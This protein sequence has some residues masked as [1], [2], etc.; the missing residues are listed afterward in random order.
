MQVI[1]NTMPPTLYVMIYPIVQ[2]LVLKGAAIETV[3][4]KVNATVVA[5][6]ANVAVSIKNVT[7]NH[8]MHCRQEMMDMI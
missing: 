2:I 1:V 4:A 8:V 7:R 5:V 6:R 3:A